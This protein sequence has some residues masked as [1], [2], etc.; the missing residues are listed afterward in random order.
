MNE[1][2]L[3]IGP[4][5][6]IDSL[7]AD[8]L[9]KVANIAQ[10]DNAINAFPEDG[11]ASS[12]PSDLLDTFVHRSI[13]LCFAEGNKSAKS[14]LKCLFKGER[15]DNLLSGYSALISAF[16]TPSKDTFVSMLEGTSRDFHWDDEHFLSLLWTSLVALGKCERFRPSL[17]RLFPLVVFATRF[18]EEYFG[19]VKGLANL[20][21]VHGVCG[22]DAMLSLVSA[23]RSFDV[24]RNAKNDILKE[25]VIFLGRQGDEI[26]ET[27]F[28][29]EVFERQIVEIKETSMNSDFI[30]LMTPFMTIGYAGAPHWAA[31]VIDA[32]DKFITSFDKLSDEQVDEILATFFYR[33]CVLTE[34]FHLARRV[35]SILLFIAAFEKDINPTIHSAFSRFITNQSLAIH[36]SEAV[37]THQL[38]IEKVFDGLY[39]LKCLNYNV[40]VT[41][42]AL[43]YLILE[44]AANKKRLSTLQLLNEV[45]SVE[46]LIFSCPYTPIALESITVV[47][48]SQP[49]HLVYFEEFDRNVKSCNLLD[50]FKMLQAL[51]NPDEDSILGASG[52]LFIAFSEK[53]AANCPEGT[54]CVI[55]A[56]Q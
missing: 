18:S 55:I 49:E 52:S 56:P 6:V 32:L 45:G 25:F 47:K 40:E 10:V 29:N 38:L 34:P 30:D 8:P 44:S 7:I 51:L 20:A 39:A 3:F 48:P 21:F 12:I 42:K 53:D 31:G 2:P 9:E 14:I 15:A 43:V 19:F 27:L 54:R 11:Q 28:A 23:L 41:E 37:K 22:D 26:V 24:P 4:I 5:R 35:V 36:S 1:S 33:A 17:L 13:F 16:L 50:R 46:H